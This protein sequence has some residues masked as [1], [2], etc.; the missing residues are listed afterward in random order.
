MYLVNS[1]LRHVSAV[2]VETKRVNRVPTRLYTGFRCSRNNNAPPYNPSAKGRWL[3][4][5]HTHHVII[6][7]LINHGREEMVN[8][9]WIEDHNGG[10]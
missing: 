9:I 8:G 1:V 5:S 3:C 6:A 4:R 2:W 10:G 7:L